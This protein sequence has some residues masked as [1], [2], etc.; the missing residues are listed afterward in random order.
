MVRDGVVSITHYGV[1][2]VE[3]ALAKPE[4][5]TQYF[6]PAVNI[7]HVQQM[8]NSVIQQATYDSIQTVSFTSETSNDK[9]EFLQQLKNLLPRLNLSEQD[10]R[11]AES[12]VA[13]IDAQFVAPRLNVNIIKAAGNVLHGI[14][15][16][17]AGNLAT[18]LLKHLAGF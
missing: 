12:E 6:P 4:E 8:S 3:A 18:D 11:Q 15:L 7:I 2:Q 16:G 13:T 14:L 9:K 17:V 5:P 10:R 1:L